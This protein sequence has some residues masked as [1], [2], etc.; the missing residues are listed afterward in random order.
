[1]S[2][3]R[4]LCNWTA[5]YCVV[6]HSL[7]AQ[8]TKTLNF[9]AKWVLL[10]RLLQIFVSESLTSVALIFLKTH[11]AD[12]Q[13]KCRFCYDLMDLTLKL[14]CVCL[15]LISDFNSNFVDFWNVKADMCYE[16]IFVISVDGIRD[17]L[18]V[19]VYYYIKGEQQMYC[20]L[21]LWELFHPF[22]SI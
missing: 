6:G 16:V 14:W 17:I 3:D 21:D 13:C 18:Y 22:H 5:L 15:D 20:M 4:I 12:K 19:W 7:Y 9:Y 2:Y 8:L 11:V 10:A 1:M